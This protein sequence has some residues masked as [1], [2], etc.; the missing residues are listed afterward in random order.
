MISIIPEDILSKVFDSNTIWKWQEASLMI[1]WEEFP[2]LINLIINQF[3]ASDN[4]FQNVSRFEAPVFINF[5]SSIYW[6][7][8]SSHSFMSVCVCVCVFMYV[9]INTI[10]IFIVWLVSQTSH[11]HPCT[12][13]CMYHKPIIIIVSA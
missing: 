1:K 7:I 11:M 2:A 12:C 8:I 4:R 6:F 13:I 10:I 5:I 3:E 9:F